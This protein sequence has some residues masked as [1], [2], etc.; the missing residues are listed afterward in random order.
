MAPLGDGRLLE[1]ALQF[2]GEALASQ[3]DDIIKQIRGI[4]RTV[5]G[6]TKN[7]TVEGKPKKLNLK[8]GKDSLGTVDLP[9]GRYRV[10]LI[11]AEDDGTPILP[12]K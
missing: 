5:G 8:L 9:P 2:G 11:V 12:R 3:K 1:A 10:M 6:V 4:V 7:L